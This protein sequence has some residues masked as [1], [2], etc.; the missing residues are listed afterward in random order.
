MENF[1]EKIFELIIASGR[2]PRQSGFPLSATKK[3]GIPIF[4]ARILFFG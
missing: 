4:R 1:M 3:T 2:P